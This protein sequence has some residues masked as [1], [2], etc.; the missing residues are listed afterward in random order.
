MG[1]EVMKDEYGMELTKE[2]Q[3]YVIKALNEF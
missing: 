2:E 3:D 1:R